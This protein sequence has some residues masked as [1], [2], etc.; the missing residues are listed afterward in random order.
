MNPLIQLM[1]E[2]ALLRLAKLA[3]TRSGSPQARMRIGAKVRRSSAEM[4]CDGCRQSIKDDGLPRGFPG[5][6]RLRKAALG[7]L[8]LKH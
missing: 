5:A 6:K 1:K 7:K 8:T 2:I 3:N 4:W